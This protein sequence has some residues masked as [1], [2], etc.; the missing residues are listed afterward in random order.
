MHTMHPNKSATLFISD[1]HL[2]DE[3]ALIS[4][5]FFRFIKEHAAGAKQ[6]FILG[7]LFEIWVGDDQLEHDAFARDVAKALL[8]LSTSGVDVLFMRGNRDFL[9]GERFASACGLTLLDDTHVITLGGKR[10]LLMHGDTLCTDDTAYQQFRAL[11]RSTT[12]QRDT[13]AKPY[14]ER[15]AMARAIRAQSSAAKAQKSDE[16]MDVTQATVDETFRRFA[17]PIMIHGHTHRPARH[18]RAI[19][20]HET[21]RW[22]LPDWREQ[23]FYLRV[24]DDIDHASVHAIEYKP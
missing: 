11:T 1:L 8:R 16:I 5:L 20:G 24:D 23:G 18:V 17:F 22:V 13:L 4:K 14:A 7:D 21:I 10:V 12:W 19:D 2:T 9:I 15:D 3:R 6:L